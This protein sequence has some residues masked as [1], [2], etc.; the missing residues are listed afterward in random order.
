MMA[1]GLEEAVREHNRGPLCVPWKPAD[2]AMATASVFVGFFILLV[3]L[4]RATSIDGVEEWHLLTPWSA[5]AIEGVLLLAVWAFGVHKYRSGW[6]AL[7]LKR[8]ERPRA[9]LLPWLALLG[10]LVFTGGYSVVVTAIGMGSL[11]PPSIPEEALGDGLPRLLNTLVIVAWGPFAEETFFR[12]F[13]LA[14]LVPALGTVRAAVVSSAIFAA[15]HL[16]L[17]MMV[18]IFVT[19]LLLSWLYLTTRSI[20]PPIAAHAAQNLIAVLLAA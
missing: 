17:G 15:A 5:G 9:L 4:R 8:P 14:G 2:V 7:G 19:G 10:S 20:W 3:V 12:G 6:R 1:A 16:M 18:P 11:L 13:L